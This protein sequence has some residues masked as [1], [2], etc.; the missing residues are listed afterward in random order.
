MKEVKPPRKPLI[1]YYGAA[2]IIIL[3]LNLLLV[4]FIEQQR[5]ESVDYSTFLTMTENEN[6]DQ[7]NL[8][9]TTVRFTVLGEPDQIYETGRMEDPD[10]V[11][12][13]YQAGAEF[14]QEIP[15]ETSPLMS[16]FLF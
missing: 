4:P 1:Y 7:V 15:R 9:E 8:T 2:L 13:L 6:I 5:V 12:R 10:L 14:T 3:L 16:F 11:N